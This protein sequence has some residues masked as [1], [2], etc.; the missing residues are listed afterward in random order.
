[1]SAGGT[2]EDMKIRN[3]AAIVTVMILFTMVLAACGGSAGGSGDVGS[4]DT[5]AKVAEDSEVRGSAANEATEDAE[6][7]G[8]AT[9]EAA[10][11]ANQSKEAYA[12][13]KS[14]FDALI[15]SEGY[16]F[17]EDISAGVDTDGTDDVDEPTLVLNYLSHKEVADPSGNLGMKS[18]QYEQREESA[19]KKETGVKYIRDGIL[20]AEMSDS[21]VKIPK[22]TSQ[23][24]SETNFLPSFTENA[25]IDA[26]IDDVDGGKQITLKVKGDVFEYYMEQHYGDLPELVYETIYGMELPEEDVANLSMTFE[27]A[28]ITARINSDGNFVEYTAALLF[29]EHIGELVT[30]L[31]WKAVATNVEIGKVTIDFPSEIDNY[32]DLD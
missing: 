25:I 20:Y 10:E 8:S 12:L 7:S 29:S 22:N 3:K 5:A 4:D 1:L 30:S 21:K 16:T 19:D 13:Y 14:A 24:Q 11:D 27:N 15:N 28:T 18:T 6:A 9:S 17:D 2:E 31:D 26:S 32:S 23:L